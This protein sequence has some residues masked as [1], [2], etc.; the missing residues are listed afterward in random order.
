MKKFKV[1]FK[2]KVP[3]SM[4]GEISEYRLITLKR[5]I[6][7]NTFKEAREK[8]RKSYKYEIVHID[9]TEAKQSWIMRMIKKLLKC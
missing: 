5:N 2:G 3:V 7:A 6:R 1:I 4:A 9:V 8:I